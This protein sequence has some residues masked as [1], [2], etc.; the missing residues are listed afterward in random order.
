M[1]SRKFSLKKQWIIDKLFKQKEHT[2]FGRYHIIKIRQNA[3]AHPRF[4]ISIGKK[5]N[6]L[7]VCRNY[8][9]RV[10]SEI[11]RREIFPRIGNR[12]LDFL[13]LGKKNSQTLSF[14][15]RKK[16]LQELF[17]KIF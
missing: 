17:E 5:T 10:V 16:D 8:A 12:K 4:A 11:I 13:V 15:E 1:L 9:R 14:I 2:F 7:A 6:S 3:L